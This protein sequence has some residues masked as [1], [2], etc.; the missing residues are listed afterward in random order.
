MPETL[1]AFDPRLT[2]FRDGVAAKYLEGKL[3]AGRFVDGNQRFCDT[4]GKPLSEIV[5]KSDADFFPVEQCQK[6]RRDAVPVR[7][8]PPVLASERVWFEPEALK[9]FKFIPLDGQNIGAIYLESDLAELNLRLKRFAE[10]VAL[11]LRGLGRLAQQ[12][13]QVQ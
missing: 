11:I 3:K 6:Y 13:A 12:P 4:I 8:A 2:P 9:L 5:G 7:P 1:P 10:M